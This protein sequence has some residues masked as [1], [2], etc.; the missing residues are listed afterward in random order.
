[1]LVASPRWA[2]LIGE[3]AVPS[4]GADALAGAP[5]VAFDEQLPI[6]RRYYRVVFGRAVRG[7]ASLVVDDVRAVRQAVAAG[8]G[9]SVLPRYLVAQAVAR[10]ELVELHRPP[11][12]PVDVVFLARRPGPPEPTADLI[13]AA[14][15][16]AAPEWE[17]R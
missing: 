13:G 7:T 6:I 16:R 11:S 1:M 5:L 15:K 17:L 9:I 10:G 3:G 12:P 14:L 4:A 8:A 2:G